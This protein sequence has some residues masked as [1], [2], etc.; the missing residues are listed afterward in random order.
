MKKRAGNFYITTGLCCSLVLALLFLSS[1]GSGQPAL[2]KNAST[3]K[4]D[5]LN[6]IKLLTPEFAALLAQN[7]E[8]AVKPALAKMVSDAAREGAPFKFRIMV[9]D[10]MGIKLAG[11]LSETN[12]GM[13]FS[14][15]DAAR[16]V[17]QQGKMASDVFYLGTTK[18]YVIGAPLENEG[19]VVGALV[20]GVFE[21][22]LKDKWH[23][24]EKEF[25]EIE[26]N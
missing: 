16:T 20:L 13:N 25:R 3:F 21:Q 19:T 26:F 6:T 10:R 17:L 22:E 18:A 7:K 1:C 9:L 11:G 8:S 14:S 5:A 4:K 15:Y 2:S 12:D 24:T 23:I